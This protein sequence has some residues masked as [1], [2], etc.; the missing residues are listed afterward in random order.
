MTFDL[1][2]TSQNISQ[3]LRSAR[4]RYCSSLTPINQYYDEIID[5]V[6][7]LVLN[8]TYSSLP[9]GIFNLLLSCRLK[10]MNSSSP[11]DFL[12]YNN[13]TL[14]DTENGN[15]IVTLKISLDDIVNKKLCSFD[16][17]TTGETTIFLYTCRIAQWFFA[18]EIL[19]RE[20]AV[21]LRKNS[22]LKLS[23]DSKTMNKLY[24]S[25]NQV[26]D[27]NDTYT[28]IKNVNTSSYICNSYCDGTDSGNSII[29]A[30]ENITAQVKIDGALATSYLMSLLKVEFKF[31]DGTLSHIAGDDC[32]QIS[33]LDIAGQMQITCIVTISADNLYLETLI[34]LDPAGRVL[35]DEDD[36]D[37]MKVQVL[38]SIIGPYTICGEEDKECKK[39]MVNLLIEDDEKDDI[40][41]KNR[42][43]NN[44]TIY[45]ICIAVLL[46]AL[47][48]TFS[49]IYYYIRRS[50]SKKNV[51]SS[52]EY[53]NDG[54]PVEIEDVGIHVDIQP[55]ADVG[56]G[57]VKEEIKDNGVMVSME[58]KRVLKEDEDLP[59]DI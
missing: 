44:N 5:G 38:R 22:E 31:E 41:N 9:T 15:Y 26:I 28:F 2:Q 30:G 47:L 23:I 17:I 35:V 34:K 42:E 8:T 33:P 37:D 32:S 58:T 19:P 10:D 1:C 52:G 55:A 25:S 6:D 57:E 13:C 49:I 24:F 3:R 21:L 39:E 40:T 51:R 36:D 14:T 53:Q 20:S 45:Y 50:K 43:D 46:F 54:N 18:T 56:M 11:L 29:L 59:N 48:I 12:D 27:I 16:K 7:I 4:Y